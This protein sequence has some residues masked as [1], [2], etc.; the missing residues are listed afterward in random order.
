MNKTLIIQEHN[1]ILMGAGWATDMY[2]LN[3]CQELS[4]EEQFHLMKRL[5]NEGILFDE[6]KLT[7]DEVE[8]SYLPKHGKMTVQDVENQYK[9]LIGE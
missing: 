6:D 4:P 5:A 1:D 2:V 7:E 9:Y 8:Q 3:F